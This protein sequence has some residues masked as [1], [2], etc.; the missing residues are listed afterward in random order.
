RARGPRRASA[1]L[2]FDFLRDFDDLP[3]A[4]IPVRGHVMTSVRLAGRLIDS[5]R[6]PFEGV[7]GA[8]H[9]TPRRRLARFLH[10]HF[11][12]SRFS[13]SKRDEKSRR[14]C[15]LGPALPIPIGSRPTAERTP[16]P[17]RAS[18]RWAA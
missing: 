8:A 13:E 1:L 7:M 10:G 5:E 18:G 16:P 11:W 3:A 17:A 15:R 4:V 6:R 12:F 2:L 14:P 9:A